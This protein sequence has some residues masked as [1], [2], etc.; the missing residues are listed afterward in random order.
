M[1]NTDLV[2]ATSV[3][4]FSLIMFIFATYYSLILMMYFTKPYVDTYLRPA[5]NEKA[6][7]V[8]YK[9]SEVK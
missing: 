6:A 8:I 1:K 3:A 7:Y 5:V 2:I 4:A 9:H